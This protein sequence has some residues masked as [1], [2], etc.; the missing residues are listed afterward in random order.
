MCVVCNLSGPIEPGGDP[1][2]GVLI[3][4]EFLESFASSRQEM[5]R[6]CDAMLLCSQKASNPDVRK[7]YDRHY[8]RMIAMAR[9]WNR[10]E[11]EREGDGGCEAKR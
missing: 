11:E 1:H 9:D 4:D 2:A 5:K 3:A 8:K 10:L 6:A 7:R